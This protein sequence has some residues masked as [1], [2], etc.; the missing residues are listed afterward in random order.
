[1]LR[2]GEVDLSQGDAAAPLPS[3]DEC[4]WVP[5]PNVALHHYFD[6][7]SADIDRYNPYSVASADEQ[8]CRALCE[9]RV[10][11]AGYSWRSADPSHEFFHKCFLISADGGRHRTSGSFASAVCSRGGAPPPTTGALRGANGTY[12]GY[13][14]A[15]EAVR[16]IDSHDLSGPSP[17]F[18]YLA[19][20]NTHAPLE[21]P[22]SFVEPYSHLGDAKREQ[23]SGML[24]FVDDTVG[25]VTAALKARPGMW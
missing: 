6:N 21:A 25:N 14:F 3:W 12:T 11:C 19:L 17:L 22:W 5:L 1:V 20:H 2:Q 23:F 10:D 18:M 7:R 8:G 9:G 16:V 4:T 24:T 13:L 15:R